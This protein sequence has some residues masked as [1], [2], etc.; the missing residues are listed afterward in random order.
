MIRR[1]SRALTHLAKLCSLNSIEL[2][3]DFNMIHRQTYA[4]VAPAANDSLDKSPPTK[5]KV[6]LD[7]MFLSKPCSLAL[8]PDFPL[9]VKDPDEVANVFLWFELSFAAGFIII[10]MAEAK[11][12]ELNRGYMEVRSSSELGPG[13]FLTFLMVVLNTTCLTNSMSM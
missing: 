10:E 12:D 5:S 8:A 7:K 6:N 4:A 13:S 11:Q 1:W 3:K 9:P 2:G